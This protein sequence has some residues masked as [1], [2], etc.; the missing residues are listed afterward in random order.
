MSFDDLFRKYL[1]ELTRS[2]SEPLPAWP[3]LAKSQH[4]GKVTQ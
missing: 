1:P 2:C 4:T 3:F